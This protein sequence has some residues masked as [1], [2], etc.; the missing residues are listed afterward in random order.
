MAKG[1]SRQYW[2]EKAEAAQKVLTLYQ[3]EKIRFYKP[4]SDKHTAFHNSLKPIRFVFGPNQC[5]KSVMGL[6]ELVMSACLAK[7]P[8]T[9]KP[10]PINGR[11][12][13]F[14]DKFS[15]VEEHIIPLLKEW[16]PRK[17]LKGG[18]WAD[19][20]TDR[21][22]MLRGGKDAYIDMLT[23]DQDYSVAES[24]TLDGVWADEEMPKAFYAGTLPRLM[25]R[26]GRMWLTVTPLHKMT[27]AMEM[28]NKT[29]DQNVDVFKLGFD[30]N[31]HLNAEWK[32]TFLE[33]CPESERAARLRGEFLEFAGLVYK[34]LDSKVHFLEHYEMPTQY[35]PVIMALDPHQRKAVACT[36]A[37]VTPHDDV[38]F[39]DE[40]QIPGSAEQIVKAIREKEAS[41]G[42]L[43]TT[44][45]IV[46][47][48]ANKQ[49]S[50]MGSAMTTL[51][52]LERAGMPFSLADNSHEGYN[53]V[54]DYLAY[55]KEKPVDSLNRPKV[56]FTSSVPKTWTGM[57]SLLW[58]EYRF[59]TDLREPKE[60]V[61][62]Y[63][64]DFPDCVRY[65]LAL[66]PSC[67]SINTEPVNLNFQMDPL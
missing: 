16:V 66:R 40:M 2:L 3:T 49:V 13:I 1:Q 61:K 9:S 57:K 37:L 51:S 58:D 50:G 42:R 39:F 65:T 48:A 34:E 45:R 36:W 21:Y 64:K 10:N 20:Y 35:C 19:A 41:H 8:F 22:H 46:D 11:W 47:P 53:I 12:R 14:T 62:D 38:V 44:L 6:N 54:H 26:N 28:W 56:Y 32:K 52:E 23:Y 31:P 4:C 63:M 17:W 29:D 67:R 25:A 27:W 55:N 30:D 43:R 7:H 18:S 59:N 33:T 15:K 24:V 60:L 5:G